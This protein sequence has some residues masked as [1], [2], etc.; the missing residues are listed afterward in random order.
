MRRGAQGGAKNRKL[1]V[2]KAKQ[3]EELRI[4]TEKQQ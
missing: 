2:L 3:K 1:Q 4:K